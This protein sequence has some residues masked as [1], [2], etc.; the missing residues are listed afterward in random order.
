MKNVT[1]RASSGSSS[2]SETIITNAFLPGQSF[3][4]QRYQNYAGEYLKEATDRHVIVQICESAAWA[5]RRSADRSWVQFLK[6]RGSLTIVPCGPVPEVRLLTPSTM[7]ACA[8][9]KNFTREIA[10]ER[11]RHETEFKAR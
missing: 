4:I 2:A 11:R 3:Q 8:L 1:S 7:I 10:L 6:E 9:E 5:E